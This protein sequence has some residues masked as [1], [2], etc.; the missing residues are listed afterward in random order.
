M[1]GLWWAATGGGRCGWWVISGGGERGR[2]RTVEAALPLARRG[3][4]SRR[5]RDMG[6]W[7][8][9]EAG[10]MQKIMRFWGFWTLLDYRILWIY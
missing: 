1:G 4:F 10:W 2:H 3:E 6:C 9:V 7:L 5:W 8:V